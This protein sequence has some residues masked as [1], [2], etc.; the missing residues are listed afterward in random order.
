M[1]TVSD[2]FHALACCLV[3][4]AVFCVC[5][6]FLH[7]VP[8]AQAPVSR[9]G[10]ADEVT[11][12]LAGLETAVRADGDQ[13]FLAVA[14]SD[15]PELDRAVFSKLHE[16]S[17]A[18]GLA[19]AGAVVATLRERDRRPEGTSYVVL[20]DLLV[21]HGVRGKVVTW[22]LT[23]KP[24]ARQGG[25]L[26]IA[27]LKQLALV[28]GLVQLALDRQRSFTVR[29]FTFT[30]PD[31]T[32]RMSSGS[33]FMAQGDVGDT[34]IVLRGRA[35]LRF[36]PPDRSEQEQLKLWSGQPALETSIEA[37]FIRLNPAAFR[38]HISEGSLVPSELGLEEGTRA[39]EIF[40]QFSARTFNLGL[41]DLSAA[42]W[43][44]LPSGDSLAVEFKTPRFGWLT[45]THSPADAEDVS[46]FDRAKGRNLS[47]YG[48]RGKGRR[49]GPV[50]R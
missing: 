41:S 45:Y 39:Q 22:E 4:S 33:A 42:R 16:G 35:E 47:V 40:D 1:A 5:L 38:A 19:A 15:L 20:A 26:E 10:P 12:L 31:L 37:V 14:S 32:I 28:D 23:L 50:L 2:R 17:A 27:G 21:S 13:A 6:L 46:L 8:R 25:R 44:L 3:P 43:S 36:T 29:N 48:S 30:A 7:A 9:A 18:P 34:A 49:A 24:T 11:R